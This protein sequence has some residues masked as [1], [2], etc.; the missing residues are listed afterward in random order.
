MEAESCPNAANERNT[1]MPNHNARDFI[2][3]PLK[4]VAIGLAVTETRNLESVSCYSITGNRSNQHR[5]TSGS[6][7]TPLVSRPYPSG[8]PALRCPA[9]QSAG[10]FFFSCRT[11]W[12]PFSALP[13]KGF[14]KTYQ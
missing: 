5:S 7:C 8:K 1:K 14:I 13:E 9:I 2:A 4:I 10:I 3:N 11:A 6:P 12:D